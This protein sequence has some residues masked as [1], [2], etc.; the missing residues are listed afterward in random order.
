MKIYNSKLISVLVCLLLVSSIFFLTDNVEAKK[1][2]N[3]KPQNTDPK[4][5]EFVN[6]VDNL[7]AAI[8]SLSSSV[9]KKPAEKRQKALIKKINAFSKT[10]LNE[11]YYEAMSKLEKDI[12]G[13]MD[14][15][16]GGKLRNDWVTD[17]VTQQQLNALIDVIVDADYDMDNLTFWDEVMAHQTDP[18]DPDTDGDGKDDGWEVENGF[19][20]TVPD[21]YNDSDGDGISDAQELAWGTNP[22]S[23]DTDSDS[24][25]GNFEDGTEIAYWQSL[26]FSLNEAIAL[27]KKPDVD[28]D[29]LKDGYEVY[30]GSNYVYWYEAE[31]QGI[32]SPGT[33]I[34]T[35]YNASDTYNSGNK[36]ITSN[37]TTFLVN[38]THN[39][40]STPLNYVLMV[41]ARTNKSADRRFEV[42]ISG[43]R[44][45]P[46]QFVSA[47][48]Y[49]SI[50][51]THFEWFYSINF[52]ATGSFQV[53]IK[54][55]TVDPS[56]PGGMTYGTGFND[57]FIDKL[58]LIVY[59]VSKITTTDDAD[60]I[61]HFPQGG[62]SIIVN[63][64]IPVTNEFVP[65][66]VSEASMDL[67]MLKRTIG[68]SVDWPSKIKFDV[69]DDGIIEWYSPDY[70]I[71]QR[72]PYD[73]ASAL[74]RFIK[75][76]PTQIDSMGFINISINISSSSQGTIRLENITIIVLPNA[77]DPLDP[78]TDTDGLM[79]GADLSAGTGLI[80]YDSDNDMLNDSAEL[81][82]GGTSTQ[83]TTTDDSD[84]IVEFQ[85]SG[86]GSKLVNLSLP[87]QTQTVPG[88]VTSA[89]MNL[90][91]LT[92]SGT[93]PSNVSIDIGD[94]SVIEWT[95]A[96]TFQTNIK[97][98]D[99]SGP[100]NN[101][102]FQNP[103][104]INSTGYIDI[105]V[106][107]TSTSQGNISLN[108][109]M[110]QI[111]PNYSDPLVPDTDSD[112]LIDG[113]EDLWGT[114]RSDPDSDNDLMTDGYEIEGGGESLQDP[115]VFNKAFAFHL[116][117]C[118]DFRMNW[119]YLNLWIKGMQNLSN[120]I[121]DITDGYML[122]GN[123][124]F[125]D[126][127]Q[128]WDL[129]HIK[130]YYDNAQIPTGWPNVKD[131]VIHLPRYFNSSQSTMWGA[132]AAGD[133]DQLN[134]TV[135]LAHEFSHLKF[136]LLDE[137][138]NASLFAYYSSVG[139]NIDEAPKCLMNNPLWITGFTVHNTNEHSTPPDIAILI[140]L[141]LQMMILT[142]NSLSTTAVQPG[143]RSSECLIVTMAPTCKL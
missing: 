122:L 99:I 27:A 108:N 88:Y 104:L 129:S 2:K 53:K 70:I 31:A 32:R 37:A 111:D 138:R 72:S 133:P 130:V 78:D 128:N 81:T 52:T 59:N 1:P 68:Q 15:Y 38:F 80:N 11:D 62:S 29:G 63:V 16:L 50:L 19:D 118:F 6:D 121:Y 110:V 116:K 132:L 10:V 34:Q 105:P 4:F 87:I 3:N 73:F 95:Q 97:L 109:I 17:P 30:L 76:N 57:I 41:K 140:Q 56:N 127:K 7:T 55:N 131:L 137:Y 28:D 48:T 124:E 94:D 60:D 107:L 20:P 8:E 114:G 82:T 45:L 135:M 75:N 51:K 36:S 22:F 142:R 123:V 86:G 49:S 74:N 143:N 66:Y 113:F 42:N 33:T 102:T 13:K 141:T 83:V 119:T 103:G 67:Q 23:A 12:W 98:P 69:G 91:G 43:N 125:Y 44:I 112:W 24:K 106:E 35:D 96:G 101:Y 26:G 39:P 134:Y 65:G 136:Y 14:G 139:D 58:A 54:E 40:G 89:L 9:L 47:W 5:D 79:D 64:S 77:S 120:Y 126:N 93:F 21:S 84:D 115:L 85:V 92:Y 71:G 90:T 117:V 25:D 18:F 46:A 100:I 61:I